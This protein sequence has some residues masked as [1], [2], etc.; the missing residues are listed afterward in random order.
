MDWPTGVTIFTWNGSARWIHTH[1]RWQLRLPAWHTMRNDGIRQSLHEICLA[2]PCGIVTL[3][4]PTERGAATIHATTPVLRLM[5]GLVDP[6]AIH[7]E[8]DLLVSQRETLGP[9]TQGHPAEACGA[10]Y[11]RLLDGS[12]TS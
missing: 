3:T 11:C 6:H 8:V 9:A 1:E 2:S 4:A 7:T 10:P 5:A 12:E